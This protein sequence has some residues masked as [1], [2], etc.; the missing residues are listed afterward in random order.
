MTTPLATAQIRQQ[1]SMVVL[2]TGHLPEIEADTVATLMESRE[3][4]GANSHR[5]WFVVSAGFV[6]DDQ[7]YN[8]LGKHADALPVLNS[9]ASDARKLG[10]RWL[11]FDADVSPTDGL[12]VYDW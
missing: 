12:A 7:E 5:E 9:L 3:I 1:E 6:E 2:M 11:M 10:V 8:P 4:N